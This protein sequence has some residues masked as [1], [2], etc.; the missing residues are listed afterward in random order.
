[1]ESL[2]INRQT[3]INYNKGL[4][5]FYIREWK[6]AQE[7][8]NKALE[9]DKDDFLSKLYLERCKKL[10]ESPVEDGWDGVITFTEK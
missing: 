7:Y 2:L 9:N 10:L 1:M 3:L 5:V 6:L 4:Q 8:F